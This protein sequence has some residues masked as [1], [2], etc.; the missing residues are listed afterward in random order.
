MVR[1]AKRDAE[2]A[3]LKA[4]VTAPS[5]TPHGGSTKWALGS[6]GSRPNRWTLAAGLILIALRLLRSQAY[7]RTRVGP[8]VVVVS[9]QRL[10]FVLDPPAVN[11]TRPERE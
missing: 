4:D 1:S 10:F 8:L 11:R 7:R 6:T 5:S 2:I 3:A 9:R